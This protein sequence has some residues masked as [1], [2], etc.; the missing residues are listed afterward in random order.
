MTDE[1]LPVPKLTVADLGTTA[2]TVTTLMIPA[3]SQYVEP[4]RDGSPW[5]TQADAEEMLVL[6]AKARMRGAAGIKPTKHQITFDSATNL[7]TLKLG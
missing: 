7:L 6:A 1:V 2:A 4:M 5:C 3:L